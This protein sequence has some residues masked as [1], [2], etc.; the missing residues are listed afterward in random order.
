MQAEQ[1][2]I[3]TCVVRILY[4]DAFQNYYSVYVG[5]SINRISIFKKTLPI[6]PENFGFTSL[7]MPSSVGDGDAVVPQSLRPG[8]PSRLVQP[9]HRPSDRDQDGPAAGRSAPPHQARARQRG[10]GGGGCA[11][12]IRMIF[13]LLFLTVT[14]MIF[15]LLLQHNA[16]RNG[17]CDD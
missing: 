10:A 12:G 1:V 17:H 6:N 11:G 2:R 7:I 4:T 5:L 13:V 14:L 3:Y 9:G 16:C 15:T 8:P